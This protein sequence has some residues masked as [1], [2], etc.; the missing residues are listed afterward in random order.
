M[1]IEQIENL[2]RHQFSTL[3]PEIIAVLKAAKRVIGEMY[4]APIDQPWREM[5]DLAKALR[6]LEGKA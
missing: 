4:P 5:Q 3:A 2:T 1:T 6:A